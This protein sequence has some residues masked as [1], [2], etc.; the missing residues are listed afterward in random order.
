MLVLEQTLFNEQM[1]GFYVVRQ[2]SAGPSDLKPILVDFQSL[3]FRV[4][5]GSWT[6]RFSSRTIWTRAAAPSFCQ[7]RLN[8]FFFLPLQRAVKSDCRNSELWRL[9]FEPRLVHAKNVA[10]AQDHSSFIYVL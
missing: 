9:P 8:H 3:D 6:P 5:C 10:V 7:G 1:S 2:E 4:K